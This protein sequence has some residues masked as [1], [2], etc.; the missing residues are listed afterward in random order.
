MTDDTLVFIEDDETEVEPLAADAIDHWQILVVDDDPEVHQST[1]FALADVEILGAKVQ[2]QS[3]YSAGEAYQYLSAHDEPAVIFLDVVME[4]SDAGLRLADQIRNELQLSK[5]R[6]ILRTGQAGYA[7]ELKVISEYDI[8]DYR[9]KNELTQVRLITSLTAALRSYQQILRLEASHRGLEQII[10]ST[11]DL[12][13]SEGFRQFSHGVLIQIGAFLNLTRSE[14]MVVVSIPNEQVVGQAL[15]LSDQTIVAATGRYE[16]L[17]ARSKQEISSGLQRQL[18]DRV[19]ASNEPY[20][21]SDGTALICHGQHFSLVVYV[22]TRRTVSGEEQGLLRVFGQNIGLM[23]DN[24]TLIERLHQQA[25]FD[26]ITLLPNRLSLEEWLDRRPEQSN[27]HRLLLIDIDYYNSFL[28]TLGPE[29]CAKLVRLYADRLQDGLR[30]V[31][32]FL[33]HLG[34]DTFAAVLSNAVDQGGVEAILN[35]EVQLTG[36]SVQLMATAVTVNLDERELS[37][38]QLLSAAHLFMKDAKQHRR[39]GLTHFPVSALENGRRNIQLLRDLVEAIGNNQLVMHYQP[40]WD[41]AGQRF[42]GM[43]ALVR[44]PHPAGHW[45]SPAEFVPLAETAGL[46]NELFQWVL[47]TVLREYAELLRQVPQAGPVAIN[48]SG[49]QLHDLSI[50]DRCRTC[51]ERFGVPSTS[52]TFEVTES[53]AIAGGIDSAIELLLR[54]KA[55]GVRIS[56]DDFGTGYSSLSYLARLPVDQLKLDRSFIQKLKE[57]SGV[58]I[59]KSIIE[60]GASLGLEVVAEGIEEET[61]A[62]LLSEMQVHSFQGYLYARPMPMADI[63]E[64]LAGAD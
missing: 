48:I 60:L 3:A 12:L 20:F 19:I 49:T 28:E 62:Q 31:S 41:V 8:N 15:E 18:I 47:N 29:K 35:L 37:G 26:P 22:D 56:L 7:P 4:S 57:S 50:V 21:G 17:I 52:L 36:L 11:R 2:L 39:R 33:A 46:S 25:F 54:L 51:A 38:R 44:W 27:R 16:G 42:H 10:S 58:A 30:G 64:L 13:S 32:E 24:L 9:V 34:D 59:V 23:S 43:E 14:G 1:G 63:V 40:K 53:A 6:I 45:V 5:T 55:S 61:E